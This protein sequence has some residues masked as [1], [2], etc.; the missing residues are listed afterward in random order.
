[1][2]EI[3]QIGAFSEHLDELDNEDKNMINLN[4]SFVKK[5]EDN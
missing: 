4:L 3:K 5:E 1:M 2:N